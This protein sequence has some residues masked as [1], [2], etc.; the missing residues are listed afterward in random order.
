MCGIVG[1]VGDG[2]PPPVDRFNEAIDLLE[3]RGPDDRGCYSSQTVM[4][5]HR[6]LSILDLTAAGRQPFAGPTKTQLLVLNG[7]IYNYLE[8]KSELQRKGH[9]FRTRTDTEV[10]LASF[11]EWGIACLHRLNGMFAF[12]IWDAEKQQL[13]LARDRFGVKPLYFATDSSGLVFASE[14]KSIL[15]L[16]PGLR[17]ANW[18]TIWSFLQHGQLHTSDRSFYTGIMSLLPAHFAVYSPGDTAPKVEKYW[19]YPAVDRDAI[20]AQASIEEFE[21][22][23]DSAVALRLRSDVPVGI[24][25]SGG[26]DS[27]AILAS[28]IGSGKKSMV[29][30]TSVFQE[31]AEDEGPWADK[32]ARKFGQRIVP[33]PA[34]TNAWMETL[35]KIAW[36]MDC[37]GYSPA[38]YPLWRLMARARELNVPVLLEGQGADEE[39]AGYSHYAVKYLLSTV[40][41]KLMLKGASE[42]ESTTTILRALTENFGRKATALWIIREMFP[43]LVQLQ[44]KRVCAGNVLRRDLLKSIDLAAGTNE[45][46]S[47]YDNYDSVS[48][49]LWRDHSKSILPGLLQYGD[50]ISMAHSIE[51]RHPFLDYR[52]VEW[53]F[54][55]PTHLKINAGKSK[56]VLREYLV[57]HGLEFVAN[58]RRKVGYLTN[59]DRWMS[60]NDYAVPREL[61]LGQESKMKNYID[62][63]ELGRLMNIHKKGAFAAGN[64]LYRLISCEIWMRSC[65]D[66]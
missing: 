19:D 25:L 1:W 57:K 30:L 56:W 16:L 40:K 44:R 64:H 45:R 59:E 10:L 51:S 29:C 14:P 46:K 27:S 66:G 50:S 65:L 36:H 9:E 47:T 11:K 5:G 8:L 31:L 38:V 53:A 60:N 4:L 37:P 49:Q 13:F 58:N 7:E 62:A 32:V 24:T 35:G 3:H 26:L 17:E 63:K 48:N 22:I 18:Q 23:F 33:V 34:P 55:R 41:N 2:S 6:R 42:S 39:L 15:H 61:L 52:L 28:A 54:S 12:A 20:D 21:E 43:F